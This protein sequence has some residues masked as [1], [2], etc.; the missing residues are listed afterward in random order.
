M[1]KALP[2]IISI[3]ASITSSMAIFLLKK[4]YTNNIE[5]KKKNREDSKLRQASMEEL[6]LSTARR[7]IKEE[8]ME[9]INKNYVTIR[10][11]DETNKAYQAYVSLG[12]NGTLHHLHDDK[13][14]K[15]KIYDDELNN[16]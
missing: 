11:F 7:S 9:H 5:L 8:M 2:Y 12:G 13:W 4:M 15:L 6:L 14:I 3:L 10:E 1:I 16:Y